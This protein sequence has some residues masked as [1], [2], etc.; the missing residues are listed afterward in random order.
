VVINI[1]EE[2]AVSTFRVEEAASII[3]HDI[4]ISE[5]D[6]L[7]GIQTACITRTTKQNF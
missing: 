1:L 2:P 4:T 7:E 3:L 5:E 6:N